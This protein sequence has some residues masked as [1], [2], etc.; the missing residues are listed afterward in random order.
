MPGRPG[1]P[2][3]DIAF[4]WLPLALPRRASPRIRSPGRS[5]RHVAGSMSDLVR[6]LLAQSTPVARDSPI[7]LDTARGLHQP[8]RSTPAAPDAPKS[9]ECYSFVTFGGATGRSFDMRLLIVE[10]NEEL[11]R[12]LAQGLG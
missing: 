10:D 11:A 1:P 7:S 3:P 6:S 4:S 8:Y 5:V 9:F 2:L 12:L